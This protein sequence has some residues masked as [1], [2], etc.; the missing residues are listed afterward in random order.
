[1]R[2]TIAAIAIGTLGG[3][4]ACS[5]VD[6]PTAPTAV[7]LT[8]SKDVAVSGRGAPL[9][10]SGGWTIS[11][12]TYGEYLPGAVPNPDPTLWWENWVHCESYAMPEFEEWNSVIL[13]QDGTRI[14]GTSRHDMGVTCWVGTPEDAW[15]SWYVDIDD[16]FEGQVVGNEVHLSFNK[17]MDVWVKPDPNSEGWVGTIR[18]RMDPRPY[19]DPYWV[20]QPFAL[21]STSNQYCWWV[22]LEP[23]YCQD[24][25]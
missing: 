13:K 22:H 20:E 6:A 18:V 3:T 21:Q 2:S 25:P 10:I 4:L 19:A 5:A 11:A 24:G 12:F 23:P 7:M 9:D 17:Y 8:S 16:A 14:T 15:V 1:M